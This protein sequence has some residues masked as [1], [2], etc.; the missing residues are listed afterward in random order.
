ME[1]SARFDGPALV[2]AAVKAAVAA[3]APRRTTTAIV[4]GMVSA[5]LSSRPE[6]LPSVP[7]AQSCPA[8]ARVFA[9]ASAEAHLEALRAKRRA[10][11]RAKKARRRA[12]H[13]SPDDDAA[14][15]GPVG[16]AP[17]SRRDVPPDVNGPADDVAAGPGCAASVA[18]R[19]D[20]VVVHA[21]HAVAP[22]AADIV[23]VVDGA[24]TGS[25]I[26]PPR[27]AITRTAGSPLASTERR[28]KHARLKA[29]PAVEVEVYQI[30]PNAS[31]FIPG[32]GDVSLGAG[33][34]RGPELGAIRKP[35]VCWEVF[36][37]QHWHPH[38]KYADAKSFSNNVMS[39]RGA[40]SSAPG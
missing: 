31:E 19:D 16:G 10:L 21:P 30:S 13:Q 29:S 8:D 5:M 39:I 27:A 3:R 11:R 34:G 22:A 15:P 24:L 12:A 28:P 23:A 25:F 1:A 9:S 18:P 38:K 35:G 17:A 33:S 2:A 37:G 7:P 26:S 6:P 14:L 4:A 20:A 40:G 36:S 32:G